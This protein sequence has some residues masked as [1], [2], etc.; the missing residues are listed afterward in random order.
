MQEQSVNGSSSLSERAS[1]VPPVQ[2]ATRGSL[3]LTPLFL[4]APSAEQLSFDNSIDQRT[5]S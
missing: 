1:D 5:S 2:I 3:D 4:Y